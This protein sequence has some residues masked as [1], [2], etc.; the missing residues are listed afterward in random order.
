MASESKSHNYHK[1]QPDPKEATTLLVQPI[2]QWWLI[3]RTMLPPSIKINSD[4]IHTTTQFTC[5]NT[6]HHIHLPLVLLRH[7]SSQD[8]QYPT[9]R[10]GDSKSSQFFFCLDGS[11]LSFGCSPLSSNVVHGILS[12]PPRSPVPRPCAFNPISVTKL[13]SI[14]APSRGL[15]LRTHTHWASLLPNR[16]TPSDRPLLFWPYLGRYHVETRFLTC[17]KPGSCPAQLTIWG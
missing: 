8:L 2:V 10:L 11:R 12:L 7:P 17:P 4:L 6:T 1:L 3:I 13:K 14:L 16:W 5:I 9:V 15:F